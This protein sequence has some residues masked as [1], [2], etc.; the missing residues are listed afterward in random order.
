GLVHIN[1]GDGDSVRAAVTDCLTKLESLGCATRHVIV[2]PMI[3]GLHEF[4]HGASV[5]PVFGA[6]VMIGDGGKLV[7]IRSDFVSLL[8]PFSE[9]YVTQALQKLRIA[10][11]FPGYRD[12]PPLDIAAVAK[13]AVALG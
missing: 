7:E 6:L 2:A 13:A 8:A 1:L 12:T 11:L 4:M 10:R 5:D 3:K 9:N